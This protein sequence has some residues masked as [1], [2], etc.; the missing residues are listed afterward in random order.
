M[1]P[2]GRLDIDI[3]GGGYATMSGTSM[4]SPHAAGVAA[5]VVAGQPMADP[6]DVKLALLTSPG[7]GG[8]SSYTYFDHLTYYFGLS[9]WRA[10]SGDLDSGQPEGYEPLVNAG[11]F[12]P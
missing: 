4:A 7:D 12:V 11:A 8:W 6:T 10:I 3:Q 2:D 5:L 9:P 1:A